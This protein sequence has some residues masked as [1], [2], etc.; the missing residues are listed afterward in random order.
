MR[1]FDACE[2]SEE[3]APLL[4]PS[5]IKR[6]PALLRGKVVAFEIVDPA[7]KSKRKVASDA[8]VRDQRWRSS[9]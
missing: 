9:R 4:L 6:A 2:R 5:F 3:A 8:G 7:S 1:F